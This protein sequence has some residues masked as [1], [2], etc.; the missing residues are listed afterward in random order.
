MAFSAESFLERFMLP[1]LVGG[2]VEVGEPLD[3]A[4]LKT[5]SACCATP[6]G[7]A[8]VL[9]PIAAART[10]VAEHCWLYPVAVELDEEALRLA[11]GLHNA[12]FLGHPGTQEIFVRRAALDRVVAFS[13]R[14]LA[15][16]A[17]PTAARL[18]ARHS[19]LARLVDL[20]RT[21]VELRFWAGRRTFIGMEP[22]AR[23]LAWSGLRRVHQRRHTVGWLSSELADGQRQLVDLVFW[24][25]PLTALLTPERPFP[26]FSLA[27]VFPY[28]AQRDVSRAVCQRYLELGLARVGPVL[29]REFWR[30]AAA[31]TAPFGAMTREQRRGLRAALAT[32]AG[33]GAPPAEPSAAAETDGGAAAD[34][35]SGRRAASLA[36]RVAAGLVQYLYAAE[37]LTGEPELPELRSGEVTAELCTVLVAAADSGLLVPT[38][39]ADV[40]ERLEKV[41]AHGRSLLGDALPQMI[42]MLRAA[43]TR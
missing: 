40:D 17:P 37:C 27:G 10:R 16:G 26:G 12:L 4:D 33:I 39:D 14:C 38:G 41:V 19:V 21:D 11:T 42:S 22:P 15:L 25:S 20:E 1:L 5:L 13:A 28:L 2:E 29:A 6:D 9:V 3:A 7:L 30:L 36:L 24:H 34:P 18:V 8:D 32:F 23:L 35:L 43:L 31:P